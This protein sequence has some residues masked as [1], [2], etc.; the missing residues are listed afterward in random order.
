MTPFLTVGSDTDVINMVKLSNLELTWYLENFCTD[1]CKFLMCPQ[2][3]LTFVSE[4]KHRPFVLILHC[5]R[6]FGTKDEFCLGTDLCSLSK[7]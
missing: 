7:Q 2:V 5:H 6:M 1:I 4:E 3:G